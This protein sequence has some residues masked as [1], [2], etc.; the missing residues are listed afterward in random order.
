MRESFFAEEDDWLED[1][2]RASVGM[3]GMRDMLAELIEMTTKKKQRVQK[4]TRAR[5]GT[6][7]QA[8]KDK[9]AV[10]CRQSAGEAVTWRA[11]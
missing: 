4:E 9:M 7:T 2:R 11:K 8:T 10:L 5:T 3:R 1:L 6:G